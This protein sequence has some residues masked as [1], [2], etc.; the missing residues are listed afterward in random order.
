[1]PEFRIN[2]TVDARNARQATEKVNRALR[3]TTTAADRLRATIGRA[4]A[5]FGGA[6]GGAAVVRTLARF[7]QSMSS[8]R[9]VTGATERQFERLEAEARRLGATTRFSA[10]QAAEGMLFLARAGFEVDEVMSS[11]EGTLRL[12]QAGALD[13]GQAADIASNILTGFRLNVDQTGRVVDVLALSANSANTTVQQMGEAMK[14]V[15]PVA[16]GVGVSVE[17]A[18]AAIGALSDAGLQ[19]SLAGTGLRR[20]I[21]ELESPS[22]KTT[23]ILRSLGLSA[24]EVR[25][26]QVGLTQALIAL[27]DAGVDTG[28]ALEIF[29]DRGGPAFEVLANSIPKVQALTG[30][31]KEAGGTAARMAEIM[32][33]NLNGALL[34]V[35]S[36]VEAVVLS[37]GKLGT[38]NVL[39]QGLRALADVLRR[40]MMS[41]RRRETRKPPDLGAPLRA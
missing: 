12:A 22:T 40:R 36:A 14:F 19:A 7:E 33:D 41:E 26:S 20:V 35:G 6:I 8:V 39:T 24:D 2:V 5:A 30:S 17:E 1:M 32:D 29:G 25:I 11:V 15:A 9:A 23:E 16:A 4:F 18:A 28:L 34:A 3:G 38:S 21:S 10:S 27:G 31:L 37:F 13:L